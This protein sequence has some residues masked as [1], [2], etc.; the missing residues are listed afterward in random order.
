MRPA[1]PP[2]ALLAL[3]F[4]A[5]LLLFPA[6]A[7]AHNTLIGSDPKDG[8]SI[9][10]LP[11]AV[12]LTF[13]QAVRLEFAQFTLRLPAG[14]EQRLGGLTA[15]GPAISAPLAGIPASPGAYGLGYRIISNDG[16]PVTGQITFTV[17]G[18]APQAAPAPLRAQDPAGEVPPGGGG[19][20]WGLLAVSL[21][22][23]ALSA[24]ALARHPSRARS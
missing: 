15:D 14:G 3:V 5:V 4:A 24:Y 23:L 19:W 1:H 20:V 21:L 11:A 6:P 2:P 13:D 22:V 9:P 16:H 10:A 17:A 7:Y 12:T 8:A 18:G